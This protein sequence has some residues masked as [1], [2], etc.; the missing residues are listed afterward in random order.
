MKV[1]KKDIGKFKLVTKEVT[2][3]METW[4]GTRTLRR[5]WDTHLTQIII[6][7][8]IRNLLP[9]DPGDTMDGG[10][11]D[12]EN[13]MFEILGK[14]SWSYNLPNGEATQGKEVEEKQKC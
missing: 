11:E 9:M 4:K 6:K 10:M 8:M 5:Y 2:A 3:D 14:I 13:E 12:F 1:R 7:L